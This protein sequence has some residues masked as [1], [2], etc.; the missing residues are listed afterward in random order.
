M[1]AFADVIVLRTNATPEERFAIIEPDIDAIVRNWTTMDDLL[2]GIE[3]S[4]E[5]QLRSAERLDES[6]VRARLAERGLTEADVERQLRRARNAAHLIGG[7]ETRYER[8]TRV[9]YVNRGGQAVISR[10]DEPGTVPG[11]RLFRLRCTACQHEY[12][13]NGSDVYSCRCPRCQAA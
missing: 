8:V 4:V 2:P 10:T 1:D 5:R 11:Q 7:A 9:G 3:S 6:A 13:V 12:A